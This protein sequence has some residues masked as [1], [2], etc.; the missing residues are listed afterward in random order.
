MPLQ[1]HWK[2]NMWQRF[3]RYKTIEKIDD[4][5]TDISDISWSM[6][7]N[8]SMYNSFGMSKLINLSSVSVF[9]YIDVFVEP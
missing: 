7:L 1:L 6:F 9:S 8:S 2:E 5:L 4:S 3:Q